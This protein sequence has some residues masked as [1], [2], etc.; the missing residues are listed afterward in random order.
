MPQCICVR[1]AN[2]PKIH[3]IQ[4]E[5]EQDLEVNSHCVVSTRRGLE[6]ATVRTTLQDHEKA[7]GYLVR[8]ASQDDEDRVDA[9]NF[10]CVDGR[11]SS[12]NWECLCRANPGKPHSPSPPHARDLRTQ[13]GHQD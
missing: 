11:W 5:T 4:V 8:Q 10:V 2:G 7:I 6:I 12:K 9:T 13:P 3:F 1:F